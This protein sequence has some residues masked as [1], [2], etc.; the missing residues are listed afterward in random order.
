[1][2]YK[3]LHWISERQ[4]CAAWLRAL[5]PDIMIM[6]L[7]HVL[8]AGHPYRHNDKAFLTLESIKNDYMLYNSSD[9]GSY[10]AG[11]NERNHYHDA[12]HRHISSNA[13]RER[14]KSLGF[15]MR[16]KQLTIEIVTIKCIA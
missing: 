11:H 15:S 9:T 10:N 5:D 4:P 16:L 3:R 8:A 12:I 1:M 7:F 14:L 13:N 2:I 6:V